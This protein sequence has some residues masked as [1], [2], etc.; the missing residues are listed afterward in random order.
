MENHHLWQLEYLANNFPGRRGSGDDRAI[1]RRRTRIL[2]DDEGAVVAGGHRVRL[3][4][5]MLPEIK[6]DMMP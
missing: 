5:L 3:V 1:L 2:V 4:V 6:V